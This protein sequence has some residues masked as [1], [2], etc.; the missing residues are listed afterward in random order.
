M[1]LLETA[2]TPPCMPTKQP[3]VAEEDRVG[4]SDCVESARGTLVTLG[5]TEEVTSTVLVVSAGLSTT[6]L[7]PEDG[8]EAMA[9]LAWMILGLNLHM[10]LR[11]WALLSIF[12][13][14]MVQGSPAVLTP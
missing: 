3:S 7:P 9:P 13:L 11:G 6:T 1:I 10:D 12:R 8:T 14:Q 2:T 4:S 5:T